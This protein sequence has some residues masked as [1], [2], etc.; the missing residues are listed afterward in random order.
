MT[1]NNRPVNIIGGGMSG[2]SAAYK[3]QQFGI[4]YELHERSAYWGGKLQ[5]TQLEGFSLDHGFQVIQSAYP[6]LAEYKQGD[7]RGRP[8]LRLGRVAAHSHGKNPHRRPCKTRN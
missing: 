2:L 7:F 5:T 3:L 1:S 6:A 4:P 8:R